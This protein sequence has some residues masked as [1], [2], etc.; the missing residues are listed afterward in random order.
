M[1]LARTQ[2]TKQAAHLFKIYTRQQSILLVAITGFWWSYRVY[3]RDQVD[4][5]VAVDE[6]E[7]EEETNYEVPDPTLLDQN[8][9]HSGLMEV[10]SDLD[11]ASTRAFEEEMYGFSLDSIKDLLAKGEH[12][13][14][15]VLPE[16]QM[17]LCERA[18]SKYLLYGTAP[19][20]Q[21]FSLILNRLHSIVHVHHDESMG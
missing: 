5:M 12:N 19:S 3:H 17:K 4:G 15:T 13:F 21:V 14:H 9:I 11:E 16:D 10:H 7:E 2:V 18:W 8:G 20:N 1:S 6:V